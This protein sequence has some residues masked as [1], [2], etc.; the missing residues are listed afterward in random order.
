MPRFVS[1]HYA[2]LA[3]HAWT[4]GPNLRHRVLGRTAPSSEAWSTT[5]Q[6][7]DV[8]PVVLRGALRRER[9]SR[10]CVLVVHGLGGAIDRHY[11]IEAAHAAHAAGVSCLR[12]GL[13]GADR[14]GED[15]YHAGLIADVAAALASPALADVEQLYVLGYSLGGHV[16]LRYALEPSDRRVRAIAAV[17]A[18]LDLELGAQLIDQPR[19][20][21][22]RNHVLSGLNEIYAAVAQRRAVPTP[23]AQLKRAR[24]IRDWDSL[25]VVRRYGFGTAENYYA[26][27]SVGPRLHELSVPSLL[28]QSQHDP[29]VPPWTYERHLQRT[30]PQLEVHSL[31]SGGHV[32]FPHVRFG[33]ALH[34]APIAEHI[35][36]WLLQH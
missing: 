31:A 35:L 20:V 4:I 22:Y 29:M 2:T 9:D 13:R 19:S 30:L 5:L 25:A 3:A 15:F 6:D 7:P 34:A 16:T 27:M 32:A 14:R 23:V 26:S 36:S 11:C 21:L 28:V 8:G 1:P 17:C 33:S 18:P 24:R 12:I 10:V